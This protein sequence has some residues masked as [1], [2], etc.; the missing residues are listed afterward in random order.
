MRNCLPLPLSL[1]LWLAL[2][3][4]RVEAQP[5]PGQTIHTQSGVSFTLPARFL[6]DPNLLALATPAGPHG[7]LA[8]VDSETP[9][10]RVLVGNVAI[11][12]EAALRT[13][14]VQSG[15]LPREFAE[16]YVAGHT[17]NAPGLSVVLGEWD[18]QRH[19]FSARLN[20]R[21]ASTARVMSLQPDDSPYWRQAASSGGDI[22]RTRC[23]LKALI[24]DGDNFEVEQA[25]SR[26]ARAASECQFAEAD[27]AAYVRAQPEG[28]FMGA[29]TTT[30]AI[31][32]LM[33]KS[34]TVV[35][36]MGPPTHTA[37]LER[38]LSAIWTSGKVEGAAEHEPSRLARLLAFSQVRP[39]RAIG[40]VLGSMVG[41]ALIIALFGWLLTKLRAPFAVAIAVPATLLLALV[42]Y[43]MATAAIPSA[44]ATSRLIGYLLAGALSFKPLR[45]R[46]GARHYA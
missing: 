46:F 45:R 4:Q 25:Q 8:L 10:I 36:V 14:P 35:S 28:Y 42:I 43:E 11:D 34:M 37:E 29:R 20:G 21:V 39:A 12:G 13:L 32:Y 22:T 16:G 7:E 27:V 1:C 31:N 15:A 19:A 30:L 33:P 17:K 9:S 38:L 5:D 40:L 41:A 44:Y 26:I 2:T 18:A 24:K 3:S 6:S 23:L